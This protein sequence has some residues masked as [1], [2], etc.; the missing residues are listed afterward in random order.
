MGG[1]RELY[2]P[3]ARAEL[4]RGRP[5]AALEA[6][7][8][9]KARGFVQQFVA[10]SLQARDGESPPVLAPADLAVF[11]AVRA[12]AGA[13]L[14]ALRDAVVPPAAR[15]G[16]A[17]PSYGSIY[18]AVQNILLAARGLGLGASL[19]TMHQMFEPEMQAFFGIPEEWGVV[20]VLPIGYPQGKFGPVTRAPAPSKTHFNRWGQGKP[21]LAAPAL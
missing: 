21:G 2:A 20:A 18:P 15:V 12:G 6:V 9:I 13:W 16:L 17:P 5:S 8:R 11:D 3:L 7:S 10:R 1:I 19:T 4:A 14:G